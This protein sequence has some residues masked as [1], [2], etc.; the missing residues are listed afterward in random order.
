MFGTQYATAVMY[1]QQEALVP[2]KVAGSGGPHGSVD[3]ASASWNSVQKHGTP[4]SVTPSV[5]S[6]AQRSGAL[7]WLPPIV[8]GVPTPLS[9]PAAGG[10]PGGRSSG[11]SKT[12]PPSM[13][14]PSTV[15]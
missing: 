7:H 12:P 13:T 5:L 1:A 6:Q 10:H 14:P 15:P 3:V 4:T 8:H 2:Q 11:T 9:L